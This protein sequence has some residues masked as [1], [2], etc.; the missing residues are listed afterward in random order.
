MIETPIECVTCWLSTRQCHDHR[1]CR[2]VYPTKKFFLSWSGFRWISD[3]HLEYS[4][5]KLKNS[6][7]FRINALWLS[8]SQDQPDVS[9]NLKY[10]IFMLCTSWLVILLDHFYEVWLWRWLCI[11]FPQQEWVASSQFLRLSSSPLS[12]SCIFVIAS[13]FIFEN[14][15]H[16]F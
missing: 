16:A 5:W 12:S 6:P 3:L 8:P 11:A 14:G 4:E 2:L 9:I 15:L 13:H 7:E 10:S 1:V